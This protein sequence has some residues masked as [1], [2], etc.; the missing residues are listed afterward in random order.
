MFIKY[1]GNKENTVVGT[2][3]LDLKEYLFLELDFAFSIQTKLFFFKFIN[4]YYV[5]LF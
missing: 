3:Y 2:F 4:T 1:Y 5:F